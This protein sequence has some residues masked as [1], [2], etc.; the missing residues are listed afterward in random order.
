[1]DAEPNEMVVIEV[2]GIL[3]RE[4]LSIELTVRQ[5]RYTIN[6]PSDRRVR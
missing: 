5:D 2:T 3:A 1:M 4:L 6:H